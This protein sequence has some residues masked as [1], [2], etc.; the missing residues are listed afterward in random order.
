M[1][2]EQPETTA[3]PHD[4]CRAVRTVPCRACA[5]AW[6]PVCP[7]GIWLAPCTSALQRCRLQAVDTAGRSVPVRPRAEDRRKSGL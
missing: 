3:G 1:Q 2:N 6:P 5:R 7:S 4:A